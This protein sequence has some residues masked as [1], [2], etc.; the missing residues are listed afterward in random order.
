[1]L[2]YGLTLIVVGIML[3]ALSIYFT[4]GIEQTFA[5]VYR[6]QDNIQVH[7]YTRYQHKLGYCAVVAFSGLVLVALG[8]YMNF[9]WIA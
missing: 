1:M 3:V 8:F 4:R 7:D 9:F 2:M 6:Q 5:R